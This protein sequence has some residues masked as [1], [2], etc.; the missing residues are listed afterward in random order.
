M[1]FARGLTFCLCVEREM[2]ES[3]LVVFKGDGQV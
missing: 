3:G 2:K 1:S